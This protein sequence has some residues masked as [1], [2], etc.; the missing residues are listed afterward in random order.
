MQQIRRVVL[1]GLLLAGGGAPVRA[2]EA[3]VPLPQL[4]GWVSD[5]DDA[6]ALFA[7]PA[8]MA[9]SRGP[10]SWLDLNFE[11]G[12]HEQGVGI[13][14]L[15]PLRFGYVHDNLGDN[16]FDT[17]AIGTGFEAAPFAF[18][19]T[20]AFHRNDS[21]IG[22]SATSHDLGL[23]FRPRR[24]VSLGLV[25]RNMNDPAFA[26][27]RLA[28][29][30]A[31]GV[32]IRPLGD[33]P[34]RLTATFQ[35]EWRTTEDAARYVVAGEYRVLDGLRVTGHWRSHPE[36]AALAV[37][38]DLPGSTLRTI[39]M[40][41][42][43]TPKRRTSVSIQTHADAFRRE[44]FPV[45]K[46]F[47]ELRLDGTYADQASGFVLL[48]AP[49]KSLHRVLQN[50]EKARSDT[51]VSGVIVR[52]GHLG[53]AFIGGVSA[54][55]QELF[56]GLLAVRE[57]GKPVVAFLEAGGGP[58]ELYVASAADRII[59][60]R[61]ARLQ[62]IG[63]SVEILRLKSAFADLGIDW[64]AVT[65]GPYKST[66]HTWFTDEAT[67]AQKAELESLVL[68][69]AAELDSTLTGARHLSPDSRNRLFSGGIV[70]ADEALTLGVIDRIGWYEDARRVAAEL[71]DS[72]TD[73][74]RTRRLDRRRYWRERWTPPPA[75]AIVLAMGG[76]E[77]GESRVNR[78]TGGRTMG[79][80][81]VVRA[82]RSAAAVS[83]V[84][85][86]V[87][88]VDSG[89]GS[90]LAS[91]QIRAEVQRIKE[92]TGLPIIVSMGDAAA[93]GGYW[94]A[95]NADA[96][97]ANPLTVTGSIGVVAMKPVFER[98][99]ERRHISRE[100]YQRGAMTD[101]FS[102]WR[103]MTAK[104]KEALDRDIR[105]TYDIFL[106][107]VAAGRRMTRAQVEA[108]A[109]G[110]IW[111]GREA[112]ERGLVDRLGSVE[113]AVV[114]AAARAGITDTYRT[115]YFTGQK[116]SFLTRLATGIEFIRTASGLVGS[117]VESGGEIELAD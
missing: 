21:G 4:I 114:E 17:Y 20:M 95:S 69:A 6:S 67:P 80:D 53:D 18:G 62:G 7:N 3:P 57:S 46:R 64:D 58:A 116:V 107:E 74:A 104:E 71:A 26:G 51:D 45:M 113:D 110:R 40:A 102:P 87:L 2:A 50:L 44:S 28:R 43:D 5:V 63:V 36:E 99:L 109:G 9:I 115:L 83:D 42:Q 112:R 29:G 56:R 66:F 68:A 70:R 78:L 98:L 77:S 19:W 1:L 34:E 88:R 105:T 59:M 65:A 101:M 92:S 117:G 76:I 15:P 97:V 96:I 73:P 61:L 72:G 25:A 16:D 24:R 47:A 38:F 30:Y 8:G 93:S 103:A 11:S 79:S 23:L 108:V 106:D 10:E 22:T 54:V 85:A 49:V 52:I 14:A 55:H 60:P 37:A 12:D 94:I 100:V 41:R 35:T 90:A 27:S 33:D 91:D 39:S 82:L 48:A 89:G 13:L 32:S 84:R 81:T 111:L 31:A 75:V 86:I